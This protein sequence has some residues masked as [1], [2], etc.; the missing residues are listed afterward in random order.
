MRCGVTG[1][2]LTLTPNHDAHGTRGLKAE[3]NPT[4]ADRIYATAWGGKHTGG[5]IEGGL[6]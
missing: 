5:L 3:F 2:G 4:E 1:E 6:I